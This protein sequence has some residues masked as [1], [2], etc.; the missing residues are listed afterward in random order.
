MPIIRNPFRR[1]DE[2]VRPATSVAEKT[3]NATTAP[4]KSIDLAEKQ[5]TEY[6]LSGRSYYLSPL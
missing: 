1:Q 4:P 2:N 6:K 5:N 3:S